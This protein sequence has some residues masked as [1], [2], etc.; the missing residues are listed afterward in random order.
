VSAVR[1]APPSTGAPLRES[2]NRRRTEPERVIF[3]AFGANATK[4]PFQILLCSKAGFLGAK[5]SSSFC[6]LTKKNAAFL[7]SKYKTKTKDRIS[8]LYKA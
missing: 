2:R 8:S 7:T 5:V 4:C 1:G 6:C 3:D